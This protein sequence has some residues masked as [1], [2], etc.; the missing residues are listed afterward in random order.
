MARLE[1]LRA[2]LTREIRIRNLVL[3]GCCSGRSWLC[4]DDSGSFALSEL[5]TAILPPRSSITGRLGKSAAGK[6]R[7]RNCNQKKSQTSFGLRRCNG[8][9][10]RQGCDR[11]RFSQDEI[12]LAHIFSPT[13]N[14]C[15][16]DQYGCVMV[17]RRVSVLNMQ[18]SV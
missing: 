16:C 2:I 13:A 17:V 15:A 9:R 10:L 8:A 5:C 3:S 7:T 12:T 18:P 1:F 6:R 4:K 11:L 14:C